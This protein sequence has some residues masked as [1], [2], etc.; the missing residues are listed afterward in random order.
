MPWRLRLRQPSASGGWR[1]EAVI[2]HHSHWEI[3]LA[4]VTIL[5]GYGAMHIMTAN[6]YRK[7][8]ERVGRLEERDGE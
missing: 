6:E 5:F 8:R 7:L 2:E 3:A 4:V 1:S